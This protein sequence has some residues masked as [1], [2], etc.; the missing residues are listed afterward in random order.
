MFQ[1]PQQRAG[2]GIMAGVAPINMSNGGSTWGD[3]GGSLYESGKDVGLGLGEG[4]KDV[5]IATGEVLGEYGRNIYDGINMPS[6]EDLGISVDDDGLS[7]DLDELGDFANEQKT[8]SEDGFLG[9]FEGK[10]ITSRDAFDFFVVDLNDPVDKA[11]ATASVGLLAFPPAAAA[12]TLARFGIKGARALT[13]LANFQKRF[14]PSKE[15]GSAVTNF[16]KRRISPTKESIEG[17]FGN[18]LRPGARV[19]QYQTNRFLGEAPDFVMSSAR[20]DEDTAGEAAGI[21]AIETQAPKIDDLVKD[22]EADAE[23]GIAKVARSIA[24]AR[25]DEFK[26]PTFRRGDKDL[27]AV[28]KEDLI[29]SGYEG[30]DALT[31]Y[32]N[33]MKFDDELGEYIKDI[34]AEGKANGGIM[35]LKNGKFIDFADSTF[36]KVVERYNKRQAAAKKAPWREQDLQPTA[37]NTRTKTNVSDNKPVLPD[38]DTATKDGMIKKGLKSTGTLGLYGAAAYGGYKLLADLADNAE[39]ELST[40]VAGDASAAEIEALKVKLADANKKLAEALED[41]TT[42]GDTTDGDTTD[43][44]NPLKQLFSKVRKG[45]SFDDPQKALYIAGQMMKPTEGFVPVNAFTVGTEA[46]V[47]YDKN[48]AEMARD[49]AAVDQVGTDLEREFLTLKSSAE[50]SLGRELEPT[51]ANELLLHVRDD[52]QSKKALMT[53]F[54]TTA[55]DLIDKDTVDRLS[56]S[57]AANYIRGIQV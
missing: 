25:S 38:G 50:I 36:G 26:S 37:P 18:P 46:G 21:A 35:R 2:G 33:D 41:N 3:V 44:G 49:Q 55:P 17:G 14:A 7:F 11:I 28:T 48:K 5:G 51:E 23:G 40:A 9:V 56:P 10:P 52:M 19:A 1:N 24:E 54:S 32:L 45:L 43:E 39:E 13:K 6:P 47:A 31:N 42:N 29:D 15:T 53:L 30:P 27:A 12:A 22:A 57:A 8:A 34:E 4:L 20:A 16:I